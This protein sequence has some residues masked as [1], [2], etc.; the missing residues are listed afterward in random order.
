MAEYSIENNEIKITVDTHG[1]ELKH[2]IRKADGREYMWSGDGAYWNR[3]SPVLF[4]FVGKLRGTSYTHEDNVYDGIPQHGFAR[5]SEFSMVEQNE[6]AIW[7]ELTPD[8]EWKSHYPFEFLLRIGYCLEGNKVHVMW[9]VRNDSDGDMYFSIGA[10]PAFLCDMNAEAEDVL[11]DYK[12]DLHTD[13]GEIES[14]LLSEQGTL[15]ATKRSFSLE[16]GKLSLSK[17]VFEKDALIIDGQ[18]INTVGIE[19]PMGETVLQ[20]HF[21][22]PQIGLWSPAGKNAPFVC[23][24][25]WFGRCDREDFAGELKDREY[26]N[27][28]Q[29]GHS[30]NKE[31]VIEL[32]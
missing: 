11:L 26:G 7:F 16:D 4:P 25:P 32:K 18:G 10:H 6:D 20:L 13:K 21:D 5:D 22:V 12:L 15:T 27:E 24:E 3:V 8:Q 1:A 19:N 28:L 2:L 30:F 29:P 23:I 17:E 9:T 14:G 31:Y